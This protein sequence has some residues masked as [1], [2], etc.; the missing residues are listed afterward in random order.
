MIDNK[1]EATHY[2]VDFEDGTFSKDVLPED[3]T[4]YEC[5]KRGAP[6]LGAA[7]AVRWVDGLTYRGN[8]RGQNQ[9]PVYRLRFFGSSVLTEITAERS[10]I[11]L[12]D[13]LPRAVRE[14]FQCKS[15]R[16]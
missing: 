6:P 14:R 10:E 12:E 16:I 9:V 7:V 8:D 1:C 3:I 15:E 5:L 2:S 13:E 11:D 4:N